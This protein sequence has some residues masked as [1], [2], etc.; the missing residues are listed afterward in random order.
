[1]EA[2][3]SAT[4][5]HASMEATVGPFVGVGDGEGV[6]P[7]ELDVPDEPPHAATR[8]AEAITATTARI[9]NGNRVLN[10][11]VQSL[12]TGWFTVK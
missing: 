10:A 8:N 1:M 7:E 5:L 9:R 2:S 11:G 6:E 3:A 4:S 12:A